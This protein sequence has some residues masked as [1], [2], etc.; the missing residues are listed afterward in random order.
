MRFVQPPHMGIAGGETAVRTGM[1]WIVLNSQEQL[2]RCFIELT[3]EEIAHAQ[4]DKGRTDTFARTHSQRNPDML[5]GEIV[6][7]VNMPKNAPHTPAASAARMQRQRPF[8]QS[9]HVAD[10]FA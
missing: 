2:R 3:F 10:I 4:H 1:A 5:D 7:T 8:D 6:L 9:N